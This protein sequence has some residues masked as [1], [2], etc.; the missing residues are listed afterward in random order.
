MADFT[1]K[2][3]N[4]LLDKILEKGY[5]VMT[6]RCYLSIKDGDMPEKFI[7]MRHDVDK[8]PG[9]SL[10]TAEIEHSKGVKATYFFRMRP[11]SYDEDIVRKMQSLGHEIGYHYEDLVLANGDKAKAIGH[12][13]ESLQTMRAIADVKTICMHGSPL[14]GIDSKDLW[15]DY[16]YKDYGIV[17]DTFFDADYKTLFYITDTG[18]MWNGH[19]V[20]RRDNV[21]EQMEWVGKGY[22]YHS[23]ADIIEALDNGSFPHKAMITTHPQRWTDNGFAWLKELVLQNA[24]NVVKRAMNKRR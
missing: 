7:V 20:S 11:C 3:Y 21:P 12:F 18:R 22:S 16:D 23:T 4:L 2:A 14:S 10:K 8:K 1:L 9:N 24:K 5:E 19:E 15:S 17:G 13:A 6:F